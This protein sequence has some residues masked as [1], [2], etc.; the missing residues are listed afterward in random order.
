MVTQPVCDT[1][2]CQAERV[3]NSVHSRPSVT[4]VG[5]AVSLATAPARHVEGLVQLT[6]T[7]VGVGTHLYTGSAP[8]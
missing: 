1:L 8:W 6:V 3:L 7:F 4:P 2:P 5:G